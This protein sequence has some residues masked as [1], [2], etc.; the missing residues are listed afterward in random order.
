MKQVEC[1]ID[2]IDGNPYR[3]KVSV[4]WKK[5]FKLIPA[6]GRPSRQ[7]W[8]TFGWAML[9]LS[10]KFK[11][12]CSPI[13]LIRPFHFLKGWGLNLKWYFLNQYSIHSFVI[14]VCKFVKNSN[15]FVFL[16]WRSRLVVMNPET[17]HNLF[18]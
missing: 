6:N 4:W 7:Y 10:I 1:T 2:L 18:E 16:F 12:L 3:R 14:R 17:W 11:R 5:C 13:Q 15:C 8:T 9:L